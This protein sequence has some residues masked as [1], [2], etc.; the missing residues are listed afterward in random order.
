MSG[1]AERKKKWKESRKNI[2]KWINL[3][4]KNEEKKIIAC[5]CVADGSHF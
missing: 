3:Y 2:S 1:E 4:N 5:S